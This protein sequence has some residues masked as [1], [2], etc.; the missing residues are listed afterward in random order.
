M[1]SHVFQLL[2]ET[3]RDEH[4]WMSGQSQRQ[5]SCFGG[6]G[7]NVWPRYVFGW[8]SRASRDACGGSVRENGWDMF[9]IWLQLF[10][11]GAGGQK[12]LGRDQCALIRS[13]PLSRSLTAPLLAQD[14]QT[15]RRRKRPGIHDR[16]HKRHGQ[17]TDVM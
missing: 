2:S 6:S 16:I 5:A 3:V 15:E 10:R 13:L 4:A 14:R 9:E 8:Q 7:Q 11:A 17:G 1:F 12:P